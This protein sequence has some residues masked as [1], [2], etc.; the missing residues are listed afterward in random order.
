MLAYG[1]ALAMAAME[2]RGFTRE[3][4]ARYHPA[5]ALGRRLTLRVS[6]IMRSGDQMAVAPLETPL[7]ETLTLI[8]KA[9]AGAAFLVDDAGVLRGIVTDGDVRRAIQRDRSVLDR[10]AAEIM[11]PNPAA[12]ITGD[13]LATEVLA[14]FEEGPRKLGEAPVVDAGGRP[15]GLLMLKDL[16]RSGIV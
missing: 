1:D 4:Y 2:A 15:V 7:I 6:D 3:D 12:V 10:P 14:L 5:G 8:T 9:G 16:I 11:T 13:P